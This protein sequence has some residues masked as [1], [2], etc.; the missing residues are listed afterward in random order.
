M[1]EI[2]C[3]EIPG[4]EIDERDLILGTRYWIVPRNCEYQIDSRILSGVFDGIKRNEATVP[5]LHFS[6][7][8]RN[9][10]NPMWQVGDDKISLR[11]WFPYKPFHR[12]YE[13]RTLSKYQTLQIQQEARRKFE[14][15]HIS[16]LELVLQ[17]PKDIVVQIVMFLSN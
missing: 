5:M 8:H 2:P 6:K 14:S 13:I 1:M 15:Y 17:L 12:F 3:K 7:T 11:A 10:Q 16:F 4:K 9:Q